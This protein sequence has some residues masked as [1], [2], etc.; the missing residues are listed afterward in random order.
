MTDSTTTI[1]QL[2]RKII[3]QKGATCPELTADIDFLKDT[4]MDS[5]DL[6]TLLVSLESELGKDPFREGF[7][8]FTT[9][10]ELAALY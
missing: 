1:L 6:A 9:V 3:E 5:L 8:H 10:G 4:P 7:K 2:T